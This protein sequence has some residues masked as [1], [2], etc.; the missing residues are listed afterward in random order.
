MQAVQLL[1]RFVVSGALDG[2]VKGTMQVR[3]RA[4]MMVR[5]GRSTRKNLG[6]Y[7]LYSPHLVNAVWERETGRCRYT[8]AKHKGPVT[9]L[10]Y[11]QSTQIMAS[12]SFDR[13]IQ[14][15]SVFPCLIMTKCTE[16]GSLWGLRM[17]RVYN[18]KGGF[19]NPIPHEA[20]GQ[21]LSLQLRG[22]R[23][24]SGGTTGLIYAYSMMAPKVV[25]ILPGHDEAVTSLSADWPRQL[26]ASGGAEGTVKLWDLRAPKSAPAGN[27]LGHSAAVSAVSLHDRTAVTSSRA[28]A[29][30]LF[31]WDLRLLAQV[32][33]CVHRGNWWSP[34]LRAHP[35]IGRSPQQPERCARGEPR[36]FEHR[37]H[38]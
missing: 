28:T 31:V 9:C 26:L 20:A 30:E 27:L 3:E 38:P 4:I 6:S 14:Y 11:D 29:G 15:S 18:M 33:S 24:L 8:F 5:A 17:H 16:L 12:G 19:T 35:A 37:G 36:R 32:T 2:R 34:A 21:V 7:D 23:M 10:R 22:D 13:T 25:S 1:P